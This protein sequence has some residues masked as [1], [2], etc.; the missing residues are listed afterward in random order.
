MNTIY[1]SFLCF[2]T[3]L[4][5][6]TSFVSCLSEDGKIDDGVAS[7]GIVSSDNNDLSSIVSKVESGVSSVVSDVSSMIDS[8][9]S[10]VSSAVNDIDSNLD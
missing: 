8:D 7:S 1:K 3:C 4:I 2:A 5:L 10:A 9:A 6:L